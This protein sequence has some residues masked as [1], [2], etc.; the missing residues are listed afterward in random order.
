MASPS[1]GRLEQL[2]VTE[3]PVPEP[4]PG[5]VRVRVH[6]SALN[7]ADFKTVTGSIKFLHGRSFPLVVGYD[8]SGV[9]DAIGSNVT[10]YALGDEVFGFLPYGGSTK[11]GAFAEQLIASASAIARKPASVGHTV[12]AAAATPALTALQAML[13]VGRLGKG[14]KVL[15]IGASGGVGSL[16]LG[17]ARKLGASVTA[18]CSTHAVDFV[19]ELGASEVIDRTK[20]D[21]LVAAGGGY[22]VV[23]DAAAAHRWSAVRHLLT[24]NGT[25]VTTLPSVSLFVDMALSV[26]S[27]TRC[28]FVAVK[29]K[30][31]DLEQLGRWLDEE[32][33]VPIES[34]VPVREVATA[35]ARMMRGQM[36]GRIAVQVAGAFG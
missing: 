4:G 8:F 5:Q 33:K 16:A 22:D 35:L 27:S 31:A 9:V 6:A 21:P 13:D 36:S 25:Y 34:T 24:T 14:G 28:R 17:V 29:P 11:Q 15:L 20:S 2:A 18:V 30:G 12:A 1:Y 7:P 32:L 19:R 10:G 26:V 3:L 23:F